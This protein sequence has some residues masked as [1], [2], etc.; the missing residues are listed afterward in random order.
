MCSEQ[1]VFRRDPLQRIQRQ[2]LEVRQFGRRGE[3]VYPLLRDMAEAVD[4]LACSIE[5]YLPALCIPG[6][7]ATDEVSNAKGVGICEA[8]DIACK[9]L[10]ERPTDSHGFQRMQDRSGQLW[11]NMIVPTLECSEFTHT[12]DSWS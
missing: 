7:D 1:P 5:A 3:R 2:H 11:G 10:D 8:N 4:S 9:T 6:E 12:K